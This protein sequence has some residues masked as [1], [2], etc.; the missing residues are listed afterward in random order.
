[1]KNGFGGQGEAVQSR[2]LWRCAGGPQ[3]DGGDEMG[4]D[5][6]PSLLSRHPLRG[7]SFNIDMPEA[8]GH[9][10]PNKMCCSW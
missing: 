3:A 5:R 8:L 2:F 7:I 6:N 10:S 4:P 1:M 9:P